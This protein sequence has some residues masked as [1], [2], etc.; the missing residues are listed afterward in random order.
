M[1]NLVRILVL[2]LLGSVIA[3]AQTPPQI[4]TTGAG[5]GAVT[6]GGGGLVV[7]DAFVIGASETGTPGTSGTTSWTHTPVGTPT[8]AAVLVSFY[9]GGG[10][11][12]TT[13]SSVTYGG[14]NMGAAAVTQNA[15]GGTGDTSQIFCLPNPPAGAKTINVNWSNP[16]AGGQYQNDWSVT[17]T[18]SNTSSC[19]SHVNSAAGTGTALSTSITSAT[20]EL[21]IDVA[22]VSNAGPTMTPGGG[23]TQIGSTT[24]TSISGAI[25]RKPG[26]ASTTMSWTSSV[27]A[28]WTQ[29]VASFH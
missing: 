16:S 13:I 17:V 4:S 24:N 14:T 12:G 22:D 25:S 23:Q 18:G 8:A 28:A 21:I 5:L 20:N 15:P 11:T 26:T 7:F 10:T 3:H 6:G 9:S 27:S 1:L 29:A 19:F 2:V